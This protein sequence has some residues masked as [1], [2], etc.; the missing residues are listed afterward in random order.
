MEG[1]GLHAADAEVAQPG[2][3]LARGPGRE[4][5]G[6]H[7]LRLVDA[8]EHAVGD[9]VG[10]G[11][12]LA[13]AGTGQHAHRAARVR[14]DLALLGVEGVEDRVGAGVHGQGGHRDDPRCRR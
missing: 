13:G 1:A 4:G 2:A 6:E 11:P 7:P 9:A 10:D 3:H 12:G 5:D 8:G 14:R